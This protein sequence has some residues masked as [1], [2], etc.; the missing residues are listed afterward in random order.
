MTE[1]IH[2]FYTFNLHFPS[3]WHIDTKHT[4]LDYK[5][6]KCYL[7]KHFAKISAVWSSDFMHGI[8]ITPISKFSFMKCPSTSICFVLSCCTGLCAIL[9]AAFL[10][11][12]SY[13][14]RLNFSFSSLSTSFIYRI[15]HT[16]LA[17]ALA[18]SCN[19]VLFFASPG[20]QISSYIRAISSSR[21]SFCDR[22]CPICISKCF[23]TPAIF[24]FERRP[25]PGLLFGCLKIQ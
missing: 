7:N 3:S 13:I 16:L 20:H 10:S 17:I 25:L 24:L 1:Y 6:V 5:K 11:Q 19:Y 15:S 8:Q 12:N 14:G 18:T 22:A 21:L 23:D 9:I 2:I 4:Q